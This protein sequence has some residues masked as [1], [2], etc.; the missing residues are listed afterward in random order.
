MT[1]S[2]TSTFIM[3][4][5]TGLDSFLSDRSSPSSRARDYAEA[6]KLRE[7]AARIRKI[8]ATVRDMKAKGITAEQV[9]A[10]G[11]QSGQIAGLTFKS[12]PDEKVYPAFAVGKGLAY[13]RSG[14]VTG[15][16]HVKESAE[17]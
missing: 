15:P 4:L 3:N 16:D 13:Y 14:N 1:K 2:K 12:K 9:L 6:A 11:R 10:A 7:E 5:S 8:V 17:G